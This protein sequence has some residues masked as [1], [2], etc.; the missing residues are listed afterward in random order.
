MQEYTQGKN[1]KLPIY[2]V[3]DEFGL[4]HDKTYVM[5]VYYN[6]ILVAQ[7]EGKSKKDAEQTAAK[8][9]LELLNVEIG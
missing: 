6:D 9:A 4:A 3:L 2:K 8:L 5:G 1:H 7:G